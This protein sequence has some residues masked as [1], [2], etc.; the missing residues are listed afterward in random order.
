MIKAHLRLLFSFLL[1]L[2]AVLLGMAYILVGRPLGSV[3]VVVIAGA[4]GGLWWRNGRAISWPMLLLVIAAALV[5][6]P[7]ALVTT[8]PALVWSYLGVI[9]TL[10]VW[11]LSR[12]QARLQ[13][14][15]QPQALIIAHLRQL[16]VLVL[17]SF[18]ALAVQQWLPLRFDFDWALISGLVLVIGLNALLRHL[19]QREVGGAK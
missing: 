9:G 6:L 3:V 12:F 7:N 13:N 2:T 11:D 5:H 17:L 8:D 14:N 15:N 19:R 4:W 18:I 16:G 1:G 10:L